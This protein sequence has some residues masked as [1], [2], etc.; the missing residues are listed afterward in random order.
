MESRIERIDAR[1]GYDLWSRTYDA[2]DSTLVAL[3]RRITLRHLRPR[4]GERILD[5]GCGTGAHLVSMARIGATVVGL[6]FSVGML[7]VARRAIP[8]AFLLQADLNRGLPI[9]TGQF[10]AVLCSLVSEHLSALAMFFQGLAAVLRDGGRLVFSA[11]H[12]EMAAAG[13]EANFEDGDTVYH[14]GAE[15]HTLQDY[16]S[17]IEA[18]GFGNLR[19]REY[20]VDEELVAVAPSAE[21]H[22]G[23]QMLLMIE[24]ERCGQ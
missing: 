7:T 17:E 2:R 21:K 15:L 24:A 14:L 18:A 5:A 19:W 22:L 16:L 12:P 4:K 11:F 13:I 9:R 8:G 20:V 10:D 6:D 1:R 23:R 3:D